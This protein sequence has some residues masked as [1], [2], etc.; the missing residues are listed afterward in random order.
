MSR[1][2]FDGM[3]ARHCSAALLD[4]KDGTLPWKCS[5]RAIEARATT[6]IVGVLPPAIA[7]SAA[8]LESV[9]S[10]RHRDRRTSRHGGPPLA[11]V[12]GK[13]RAQIERVKNSEALVQYQT[14]E[15]KRLGVRIHAIAFVGTMILMSAIN[16]FTGKPYWVFWVIP[17]WTIGL[18]C[19]W[20]FVLGRGARKS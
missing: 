14:E 11:T 3:S 13:R 15:Q 9:H 16:L 18:F 20:Y 1:R 6:T 8:W 5:H 17:G 10:L 7:S 4:A 12:R 19:H 2:L